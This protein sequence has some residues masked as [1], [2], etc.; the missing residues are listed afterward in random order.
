MGPAYG[1]CRKIHAMWVEHYAW[2]KVPE[3][4]VGPDMVGESLV[5]GVSCGVRRDLPV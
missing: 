3:I 2:G 5:F 4:C 1:W